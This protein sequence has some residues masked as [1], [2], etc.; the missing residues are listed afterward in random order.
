MRRSAR[1]ANVAALYEFVDGNFLNNKR[2][3]IPGG[4]W[5][6]E[7]LRRKSLADLQQVWLSLLKERNMLSTIREHYLKHQEELGAMPAPSRLKMVEDSMENV[8][9]VVKERDAEATAEAVRIFQERLAKGIY[10]YPPGP[11]PPPGAHCSMCTVKLVLSRRVDEERL[12]ELLGRFDVFEE[13]KGIVALTMQ[14]PEEVLAKKRDAEQLWQQYM[15]ER[16]DVEEYYKWPGSSTG[17]AESASVYD[18]TVVELAP[19]VYS[20]HR[21]TSAAESNGKDDGN[22][23]AHD[24]VQAAQLPVPPPKTRPP[25]PRSPLEHIKYQQRSV[26]SKTVIQ[27]GYFPNITTTPPQ[28]TKVDDVPR[29]VH[30][31]EIEGPWEVRVTYDAKDGLAYVQSL[32]LTSIDGAVVLSVEEEVPATAQPYAAVDPVYQEAV[33]REMAQEETLMKWPNV[34]EWKYQYDLYTKKNLAQ[35]VQYN[36]SNVVDYIDREVLLT[37]RSVWESPIDID[38]TCGGMKSVPAHAK[39]PKRYMTHGLSEVGVTDI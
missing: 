30:P 37:G 23:V 19:G 33:R 20:G 12:R 22:A 17:G 11:P 18:Y 16:R 31:D 27:L 15:T 4:A 28:Y 14:L 1:R 3:A 32:G 10:R 25:P 2:P 7:C 34:P 6:L 21:G 8:K 24:V 36:Y 9:R 35:V 26:L 13:H 38:P 29:P 5:P 39:K